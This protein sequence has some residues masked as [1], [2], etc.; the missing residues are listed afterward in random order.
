MLNFGGVVE[1]SKHQLDPTC[2]TCP[3]R[4][5][6]R[7]TFHLRAMLPALSMPRVMRP[8]WARSRKVG[9]FFPEKT[10]I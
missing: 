8:F 1:K 6:G 2:P 3:L 10:P 5:T 7:L 4:T 9:F